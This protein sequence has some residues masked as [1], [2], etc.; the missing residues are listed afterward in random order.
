MRRIISRFESPQVRKNAAKIIKIQVRFLNKGWRRNNMKIVSMVY[1]FVKLRKLDDWLTFS[2]VDD[3]SLMTPDEI[4][5]LNTDF[6][7]NNYG[8]FYEGPVAEGDGG[9]EGGAEGSEEQPSKK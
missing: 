5:H 3:E 4:R 9:E 8:Q 6:N 7:Y 2:E 1:Q